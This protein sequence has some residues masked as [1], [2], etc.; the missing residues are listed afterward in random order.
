MDTR[1]W[2]EAEYQS[3]LSK[4]P[5]SIRMQHHLY[6]SEEPAIKELEYEISLSDF[7]ESDEDFNELAVYYERKEDYIRDHPGPA[8]L[9]ERFTS[10]KI[11]QL[12]D[13]WMDE[14]LTEAA[15]RELVQ[16]F[17]R[18]CY[19]LDRIEATLLRMQDFGMS[20]AS[21]LDAVSACHELLIHAPET[22]PSRLENLRSLT[23][24]TPFQAAYMVREHACYLTFSDATV[25]HSVK[26]LAGELAF[27]QPAVHYHAFFNRIE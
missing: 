27:S 22:L 5:D 1:S 11:V 21:A 23:V 16:Y 9:E 3:L 15:S 20:P 19:T 2:A 25:S 18:T 24:M 14:H 12:V 26:T 13:R 7:E 17:L 10:G 4:I 8:F 6:K